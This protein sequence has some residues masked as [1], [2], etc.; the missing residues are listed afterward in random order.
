MYGFTDYSSS[1]TNSF[2]NNKFGNF[3]WGAQPLYLDAMMNH[4]LNTP[5]LATNSEWHDGDYED[6]INDYDNV[7]KY[8]AGYVMS[9]LDLGPD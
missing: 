7:E 8:Y 2:L 9:E 1:I 5:G 6:K 3:I 4:V